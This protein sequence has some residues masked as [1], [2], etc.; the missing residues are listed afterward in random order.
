MSQSELLTYLEGIA[1]GGQ[2]DANHEHYQL[3]ARFRQD[4]LDALHRFENNLL[5]LQSRLGHLDPDRARAVLVTVRDLQRREAAARQAATKAGQN[6]NHVVVTHSELN[7]KHEKLEAELEKAKE[8]V[9]KAQLRVEVAEQRQ[10]EAVE[11]LNPQAVSEALKVTNRH[12][13]TQ[14][15]ERKRL[16]SE[17]QSLR[18]LYDT[19]LP[20]EQVKDLIRA[21]DAAREQ[22][23]KLTGE[24]DTARD[25]VKGPES[26]NQQIVDECQQLQARE[27]APAN[28]HAVERLRAAEQ[29]MQGLKALLE[30]RGR[31][32]ALQSTR[33]QD[34]ERN[35]EQQRKRIEELEE[36]LRQVTPTTTTVVAMSPN[37]PWEA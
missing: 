10:H 6:T 30:E 22:V 14:E 31:Y 24:L 5:S 18:A 29:E 26:T 16:E 27:G 35:N 25:T 4:T 37:R 33:I 20:E 1:Q 28:L 12:L 8:Q 17:L 23:L 19:T 36:K 9:A 15:A 13:G 3:F 7:E 11:A 2:R 21:R 32:V 34:L